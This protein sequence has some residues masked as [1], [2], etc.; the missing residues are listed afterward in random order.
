MTV[1]GGNFVLRMLRTFTILLALAVVSTAI[2]GRDRIFRSFPNERISFGTVYTVAQDKDGFI[3]IGGNGIWRFDGNSLVDIRHLFPGQPLP[4]QAFRI[5]VDRRGY[6]WILGYESDLYR[7]DFPKQTVEQVISAS[8]GEV[9]YDIESGSEEDM[10]VGT[11]RGL[12]RISLDDGSINSLSAVP[13]FAVGCASDPERCI[14]VST[15]SVRFFGRGYQLQRSLSLDGMSSVANIRSV[16]RIG[17]AEALLGAVFAGGLWL[18]SD[19]KT[20]PLIRN[21]SVYNIEYHDREGLFWI[22]TEEGIYTYDAETGR[23]E[24]IHKVAANSLG[25]PDNYVCSLLQDKEGGMWV[26]TYFKGLCYCPNLSVDLRLCPAV[27]GEGGFRGNVVKAFCG[28]RYG[29]LWIATE[30]D[31]LNRLGANGQYTNYSKKNPANPL[32]SINIRDMLV[33]DDRLW[34]ATYDSGIDVLDIPS[35]RVLRNYNMHGDSGLTTNTILC[36]CLWNGE[37]YVGT[38]IGLFRCDRTTSTFHPLY[39]DVAGYVTS[40]HVDSQNRLWSTSYNKICRIENDTVV[41]YG[42]DPRD[43][44][45]PVSQNPYHVNEDCDGTIWI[46]GNGGL[47]RWTGNEEAPFDNFIMDADS[48]SYLN[49]LFRVE[50]DRFGLLWCS[51]PTGLIRFDPATGRKE[52][53]TSRDHLNDSRFYNASYQDTDG[54]IYIGTLN[55]YVRIN[56]DKP[57]RRLEAP[58]IVLTKVSYKDSGHKRDTSIYLLP[59][60]RSRF[61]H[62]QNNIRFEY[63]VPE[64]TLLDNIEY[65][66][67]L[68]GFD[69]DS[70]VST[71]N[72]P[73]V[74]QNLPP[75]EYSFLVGARRMSDAGRTQYARYDFRIRPPFATSVWGYVSYAALLIGAFWALLAYRNRKLV[76]RQREVVRDFEMQKEKELY[77]AKIL[78]F[79]NVAHEIRTP[80]TLIK[81]PLEQLATTD[82]ASEKREIH[83]L[84][85]KNVERLT[86]LCSQLLHFRSVEKDSL[87]LNFVKSDIG[88]LVGSVLSDFRS[89]IARRGISISV[90]C[91]AKVVAD[92]DVDAFVKICSNLLGNAIKYCDR[93]IGVRIEL[94][95]GACLLSVL[96]DGELIPTADS[97]KIFTLFYRA[98]NSL[99]KV[100][101][102]IG[103]AFTR[104]LVEMHSGRIEV[105]F[106]EE[107]MNHF[108]VTFPLD[109]PY[110]FETGGTDDE[111]DG[112]VFDFRS[113][114]GQDTVLLVEDDRNLRTYERKRLSAKYNVIAVS[115]GRKAFDILQGRNTVSLV[116]SDILMPVMDGL[117]LC[118]R[119]KGSVELSHIPVILLTSK[120]DV[121]TKLESLAYGADDY[122]T[123]P[124][125]MEYLMLR[126][127]NIIRNREKIYRKINAEGI[128]WTTKIPAGENADAVFLRHFSE[129][130]ES[131]LSNTNLN[132]DYLADRMNVSRSTLYKKVKS[133]TDLAPNDYIRIVRLKRAVH[134]LVHQ[135][136][137][138]KDVAFSVGFAST[139]YFS[140]C[141]VRQYG[142]SP[143]EFVQRALRQEQQ[144]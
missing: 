3:W 100:G 112:E 7:C 39:H 32:S 136:R 26:G 130:I 140:T 37:L 46:A 93:T 104:Q 49:E 118:S 28:D 110:S 106:D 10:L 56:P 25:L 2:Y 91:P 121:E 14:C 124:F 4:S 107:G 30:D 105:L 51:S 80:L 18:C 77:N 125:S 11:G 63:S 71:Q 55:G 21:V 38:G 102:G 44:H 34:I 70:T 97:E 119:I 133:A 87:Y 76:K 22:A 36:F 19:G 73:A 88:S 17:E 42:Y 126:I 86:R 122:L 60:E 128:D 13:A 117:E 139:T 95:Q 108:R 20:I 75:G 116:V 78:F 92:V 23:I 109:Q 113:D 99:N 35:G 1:A 103:L 85:S 65:T 123:K 57:L 143:S 141:F 31:G 64:Y 16:C 131:E 89:E 54:G 12:L 62:Y 5:E 40:L 144:G 41:A 82:D 74:Y 111:G 96:N 15:D 59:M 101:S 33:L 84:I 9:I 137:M 98:G 53:F 132:M 24:N 66:C 135:R 90:A 129:L 69:T 47:S 138:V 94:H 79:T 58:E 45:S 67:F 43:A 72:R 50:P 48:L 52:I 6:L 120:E 68:E 134:M 115:N 114:S 142:I 29:N 27:P 81:S 8:S 83:N 127:D 61:R